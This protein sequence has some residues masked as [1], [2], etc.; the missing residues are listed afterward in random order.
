MAYKQREGLR[1]KRKRNDAA[2]DVINLDAVT[3]PPTAADQHSQWV[4]TS[5]VQD[6]RVLVTEEWL[7]G[8]LI[9]AGQQLIQQAFPH[10]QGLQSVTLGH[11]LAWKPLG[12]HF[13]DWVQPR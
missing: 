4:S 11:A 13:H 3:T 12:H 7:N 9:N 1:L 6:E 2:V 10:V 5:T 8:S